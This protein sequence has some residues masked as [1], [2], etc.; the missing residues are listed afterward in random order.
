MPSPSLLQ[1]DL[2]K[3]LHAFASRPK[4]LH[5]VNW[6]LLGS[7][8]VM[9]NPGFG[10][11]ASRQLIIII[12][13]SMILIATSIILATIP[14]S[15]LVFSRIVP[16]VMTVEALMI[17][18]EPN[19]LDLRKLMFRVIFYLFLAGG[20]ACGLALRRSGLIDLR[21]FKA[22]SPLLITFSSLGYLFA[23]SRIGQVG[24]NIVS[25]E[26][27]PV[28]IC[29]VYGILASFMFV[30][31]VTG[32]LFCKLTAA[33]AFT[34]ALAVMLDTGSRGGFL[35]LL[36]S[37][38]FYCFS[39]L[40]GGTFRKKILIIG[41]WTSLFILVPTLLNNFGLGDQFQ[42]IIERFEAINSGHVDPS[43]LERDLL[44]EYYFDNFDHW[45]V[46]GFQGYEGPYPHNIFLEL[47]IRFGILGFS[48]SLGLVLVIW[49]LLTMILVLPN[50]ELVMLIILPTLFNI[51]NAQTSLALEYNRLLMLGIGFIVSTPSIYTL[52]L[53]SYSSYFVGKNPLSDSFGNRRSGQIAFPLHSRQIGSQG[54]SDAAPGSGELT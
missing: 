1:P 26:F 42:Y 38:G 50:N 20:I 25:D 15:L 8:F 9:S 34:L 5:P 52:S 39:I 17:V 45:S 18:N 14:S 2:P 54:S 16:V 22:I 3:T 31:M 37:I 51:V 6:I 36:V 44:R 21:L 23:G 35:S 32:R 10:T 41:I 33:F 53:A 43:I 40:S 30:I 19:S 7:C 12:G 49:R 46:T 24:R 11:T 29:Y 13:C 27:S 47:W 4:P 28:G 48:L